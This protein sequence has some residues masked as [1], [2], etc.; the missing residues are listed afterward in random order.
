MRWKLL[1]I[2]SLLAAIAG[3]GAGAGMGHLLAIPPDGLVSGGLHGTLL[4]L[5]PLAAVTYASIFVYRHTARRRK[6]QAFLTALLSL[7]LAA[8]ALLAVARY[9]AP[10][11]ELSHPNTSNGLPGR[12]DG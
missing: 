4:L 3:V 9:L 10:S 6:L 7:L 12:S 2:A 8:A 1:A 5:F 11:N